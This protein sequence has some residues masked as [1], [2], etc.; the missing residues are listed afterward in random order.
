[1]TLASDMCFLTV[2][3]IQVENKIPLGA[4]SWFVDGCFLS[5]SSH[6]LMDS[7][8]S[9]QYAFPDRH[10]KTFELP[11]LPNLIQWDFMLSCQEC[12]CLQ[13]TRRPKSEFKLLNCLINETKNSRREP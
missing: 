1:M 8:F 6:G 9:T 10:S 12:V 5:M 13:P 11:R 3:Y 4:C 2:P 7:V